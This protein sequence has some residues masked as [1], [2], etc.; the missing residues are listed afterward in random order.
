M[1]ASDASKLMLDPEAPIIGIPGTNSETI[2]D[3]AAK[4]AVKAISRADSFNF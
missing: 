2:H 1:G 3:K 4:I